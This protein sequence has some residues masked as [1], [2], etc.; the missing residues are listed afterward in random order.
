MLQVKNKRIINFYNTHTE[1]DFESM[2]LLLVGLL[3]K[4]S[5]TKN[6][7]REDILLTSFKKMEAEMIDMREKISCSTQ[8]IM[9]LQTT[10]ASIPKSMTDHLTPQLSTIKDKSVK[11]IERALE[12]NK[13]STGEQ[14]DTKLKTILINNF[15]NIMD[16]NIVQLKSEI[17]KNNS[18][19][20]LINSINGNFQS[21]CDSLQQ[22]I[23]NLIKQLHDSS[24][25]QSDILKDVRVYF[26]RQKNSNY[27]GIDSEITLEQ[28]LNETFPDAIVTNTTGQSCSG[29][30]SLE[31]S[32]KPKIMIENKFHSANVTIPDIE[33]FI[34]DS[35]YQCCHGIL[36]SQK[37]GISRKKNFQID[38]H[39]G[40]IMVYI[41]NA[42]YD[43]DKIKLAVDAIDH[44][45][46]ALK[47]NGTDSVQLQVS[48]DGIKEINDEYQRFLIHRNS[49]AESLKLFNR[50]M[51]KQISQLEF[52]ELSKV[53]SQQFTSTEETL[54]KCQYCKLKVYKNAKALAKHVQKCKNDHKVINIDA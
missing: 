33:K 6:A 10:V 3:E 12:I 44:L 40:Y 13:H 42:D 29:D 23:L 8:G 28:G 25:K 36:I 39:N 11:D 26:D 46:V 17:G 19:Q 1:F 48:P 22:F 32:D 15:K 2:N 51:T 20:E 21:R 30:F 24:T 43:F 41:H 16:S 4:I 5:D 27:K 37:S 54:F 47:Q 49:L 34:R 45:C 53:L 52:P 35:E 50:N 9:N 7:N 38:I 14:I 31:R 18:S